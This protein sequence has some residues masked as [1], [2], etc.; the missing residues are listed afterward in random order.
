MYVIKKDDILSWSFEYSTA[1]LH[2]GTM[3]NASLCSSLYLFL[4]L[5]CQPCIFSNFCRKHIFFLVS[6][7]F[8]ERI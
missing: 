1:L 6:A 3:V 7:F 8:I 4:Y 2:V 5:L